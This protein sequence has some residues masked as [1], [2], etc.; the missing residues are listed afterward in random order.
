MLSSLLKRIAF[1]DW[2]QRISAILTGIYLYQFVIWIMKEDGLWLP[3]TVV[4][5]QE[6]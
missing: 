5:S 3:E 1:T 6:H 4:L 2:E